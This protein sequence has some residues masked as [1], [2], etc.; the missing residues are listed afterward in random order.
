MRRPAI[1]FPAGARGFTLVE[2]LLSLA[3]LATLLVA[4]NQFVLSMGELWGS[5]R[6]QRLFDQHVRA[7][8]RYLENLL[9]RA[10]L[11]PELAR[12]PRLAASV[13]PGVGT[14]P[15]LTFDLPAGDRLL[16]W[17]DQ[18]L[19]DVQCAL[20]VVSGKGLLLYWQSRLE[21]DFERT[22]P[23]STVISPLVGR[24]EY[25][26]FRPESRTWG[27]EPEVAAGDPKAP[28]TPARVRLHFQH[29]RFTANEVV[30]VPPAVAALPVF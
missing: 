3:L 24:L 13:V 12:R 17:P 25:E 4:M 23:R 14:G 19:P 8:T 22:S 18:P 30:L 6:Q 27:T 16:P 28:A 20:D 9:Q 7:S 29:G 5:N 10:S 1:L 11:D 26:Y 2:V 15:M 21:L